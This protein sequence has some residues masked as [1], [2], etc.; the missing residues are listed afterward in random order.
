MTTVLAT[1][2]KR[3]TAE[4][5]FEFVHRPDN[6]GRWFE[7]VRG[8][9]IELSRP[10]LAHGVVCG[11][12][13]GMLWSY[14]FS[15]RKGFIAANDTGIVLE[16]DPDTVRGPDVAYLEGVKSLADLPQKW[17]EFAPRL[18]VEVLSPNNRADQI[19]RKILDYLRNGVELVWLVDPEVRSVTVYTPHN[20]PRSFAD[21]D[22]LT[23]ED[24]LLGFKCKVAD[25]FFIPEEQAGTEPKSKP[26]STGRRK[27]K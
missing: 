12:A 6:E 1:P 20:G 10:T 2:P 8:E 11:N 16:R 14:S 7:L 24:V 9:V 18:V 5:F 3:L 25:F 19:N 13:G 22:E 27:K 15:R 21:E 4:E 23:G 26:K 17:A